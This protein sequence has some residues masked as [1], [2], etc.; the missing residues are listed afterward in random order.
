MVLCEKHG[1]SEMVLVSPDIFLLMRNSQKIK[2]PQSFDYEIDG[3]IVFCSFL[4]KEFAAENNV[5]G[6]NVEELP[7]DYPEW[8][9]QLKPK[10]IHCL[11]EAIED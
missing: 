9:R 2:Q 5:L 4:S 10:C 8:V 7:D 11:E 1:V 6:K 3:D